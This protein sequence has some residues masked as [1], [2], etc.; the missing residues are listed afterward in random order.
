MYLCLKRDTNKTSLSVRGAFAK[1][2][3]AMRVKG[4]GKWFDLP[5]V[6]DPAVALLSKVSFNARGE[7]C[8]IACWMVGKT[9]NKQ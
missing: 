8:T 6:G 4:G 9:P 7:S 1:F 5:G 3:S 2:A